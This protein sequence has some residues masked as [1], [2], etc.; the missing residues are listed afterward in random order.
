VFQPER[1]KQMP[2][3]TPFKIK[4]AL[5]FLIALVS[6]AGTSVETKAPRAVPAPSWSTSTDVGTTVETKY[7]KP[8]VVTQ[9]CT[10]REHWSDEIWCTGLSHAGG[11]CDGAEGALPANSI[12]I[13]SNPTLAPVCGWYDRSDAGSGTLKCPWF[14]S[15]FSRVYVKFDVKH[16]VTSGPVEKI[17]YAAL[18]WKT[19]R[20][21]GTQSQACIKFLWEATSMWVRGKTSVILVASN[22]D[23]TA[24]KAGYVGVAKQVQKWFT[25][26]DQNMGFVI[27]PSH[28]FNEQYSDSKCLESLEDLRLTVKYRVKP[29]QWPG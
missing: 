6:L 3:S 26:P 7:L 4:I 8:V 13:L 27:E 11:A 5:F 15:K 29:I 2:T 16:V 1:R 14:I 18:S 9:D 28:N 17:D 10:T 21:V 24:A 22:L 12:K 25:F 23:T 19:K 20:L